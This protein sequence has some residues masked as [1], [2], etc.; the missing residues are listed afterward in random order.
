MRK[1]LIALLTALL[2]LVGAAAM[3]E[4]YRVANENGNNFGKLLLQL[5][6]SY[7]NPSP[8]DAQ[9]IAGT[10]ADI[11]AVSAGDHAIARSI[12]DHWNAVCVNA[13]DSYPF[14]VYGGGERAVELE[15][16]EIRDSAT[17]AFVVLGFELKNGEMRDELKGRCEAAAAA[18]RSYPSALIVCS[19]GA[20]GKNNPEQHTE[21]GRMRDYLVENCGID[22]DRIFIDERAMTTAEN[23]VNT[24]E[25][26]RAQGV[27]TMTIVTSSYHQKRGQVLYNAMAE[28]YGQACGYRPEIV[29]NYSYK[30][31]NSNQRDPE[32]RLAARQLADIVGLPD[33]VIKALKARLF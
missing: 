13:D 33:D 21:A 17:H 6:S 24:M 14:Y 5:V 31:A 12:V 1:R 30:I 15:Q 27:E 19:G 7:E 32:D 26:L 3:G 29:G 11:A 28:V 8:G 20:T 10:L 18:A 9:A 2:L 16:S 4:G 23:A 25:I 22:A